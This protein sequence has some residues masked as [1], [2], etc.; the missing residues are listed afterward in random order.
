MLLQIRSTK[1]SFG[2]EVPSL[3]AILPRRNST[4]SSCA[5]G[6]IGCELPGAGLAGWVGFEGG[7]GAGAGGFC[8]SAPGPR[9][10]ITKLMATRLSV[11]WF[12]NLVSSLKTNLQHF[13]MGKKRNLTPFEYRGHTRK[14]NKVLGAAICYDPRQ[15]R[16]LAR[17]LTAL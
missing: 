4:R 13:R 11:E 10:P 9:R 5:P 7:G 8:A 1:A 17:H 16:H 2:R 12:T 6:S 14:S 3:V 15:L